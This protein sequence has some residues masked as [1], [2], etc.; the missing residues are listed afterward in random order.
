[1]IVAELEEFLSEDMSRLIALALDGEEQVT[2]ETLHTYLASMEAVELSEEQLDAVQ[3]EIRV[4][5]VEEEDG[6]IYEISV[7]M[8]WEEQET[9]ISAMLPS[10]EVAIDVEGMYSEENRTDFAMNHSVEWTDADGMVVWK[11]SALVDMPHALTNSE[12]GFADRFEVHTTEG[13]NVP[14]IEYTQG[15]ALESHSHSVLMASYAGCGTYGIS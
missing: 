2:S 5:P 4:V 8:C 12:N 3:F 14:E 11:A 9:E 7:W 13:S 15:D 1:M 6:S 10:L